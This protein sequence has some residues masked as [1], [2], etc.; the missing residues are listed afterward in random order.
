MDPSSAFHTATHLSNL[1]SVSEHLPVRM[2]AGQGLV[3]IADLL[4]TDQRNEIVVDLLRELETGQEEISRYIPKYL[5]TLLCRLPMKEV[6]EGLTFLEDFVHASSVSPARAALLTLG[7]ILSEL[8]RSGRDGDPLVT[9][10]IGLLL[11]GVPTT[12]TPFIRRPCRSSARMYW[13]RTVCPCRCASP[14][15]CK[16]ARSC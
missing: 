10:V 2:K 1:L 6:E 9:R 8:A 7:V 12:T 15:S 5:G 11:T 4:T 16:S 14:I 13:A 3:E